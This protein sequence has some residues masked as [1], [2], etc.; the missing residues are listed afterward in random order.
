VPPARLA[1]LRRQAAPSPARQVSPSFF[2]LARVCAGRFSVQKKT[3]G[4][5]HLLG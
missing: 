3:P 2:F 5:P 4:K 1:S